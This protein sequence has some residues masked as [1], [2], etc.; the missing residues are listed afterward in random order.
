MI[1]IYTIGVYNSTEETFFDKLKVNEIDL[2]CDVRQRRGVRGAKYKYVNSI[3][4]QSKLSEMGIEYMHIK[5]LAPTNEIRQMQKEA[6]L[7]KGEVKNERVRLDEVFISEYRRKILCKFSMDQLVEVIESKAVK[8]IVF[9]CVEEH[10]AACHRSL[11]ALEFKKIVGS[12]I[13]NL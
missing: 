10:A 2:F 4:L 11:V 5:E 8:N 6:D 9:F 1:N 7:L 12:E 13:R 3:Y